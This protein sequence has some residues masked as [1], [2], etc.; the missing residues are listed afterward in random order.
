MLFNTDGIPASTVSRAHFRLARC[1]FELNSYDEAKA[2]MENYDK[3]MDS[4]T[5]SIS[6]PAVTKLKRDIN[7]KRNE[8]KNKGKKP[9]MSLTSTPPYKPP[10]RMTYEAKVLG[11][12]STS[13]FQTD[14]APA[15]LCVRQPPE[16]HMYD[17]ML[18]V[19]E[20]HYDDIFYARPFWSCWICGAHAQTMLHLPAAYLH[21]PSPLIVDLIRPVCGRTGGCKSERHTDYIERMLERFALETAS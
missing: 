13:I 14:V 20:R 8:M 5:I 6:Q 21:L 17:F 1:Y 18:S 2:Q 19:V 16:R 11:P 3:S 12:D 9:Q 10:R 15:Y 4:T 7:D